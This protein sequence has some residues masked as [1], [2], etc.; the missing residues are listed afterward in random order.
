MAAGRTRDGTFMYYGPGVI[1]SF[2]FHKGWTMQF[3]GMGVS[4]DC[5]VVR[6]V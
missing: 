5:V 6:V 4:V 3:D 1:K 2:V